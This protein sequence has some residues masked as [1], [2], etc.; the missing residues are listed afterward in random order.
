MLIPAWDLG[1]TWIGADRVLPRERYNFIG[2]ST[3]TRHIL[4]SNYSG[5]ALVDPVLSWS[6]ETDGHA[7]ACL[8]YTS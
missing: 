3:L 8:L 5:S 1:R 4:V 7:W 2:G 6:L